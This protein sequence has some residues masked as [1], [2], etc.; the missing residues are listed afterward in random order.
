[1]L[2]YLVYFPHEDFVTCASA[3]FC[4][5]AANAISTGSSRLPS[6]WDHPEAPPHPLAVP[7]AAPAGT[8]TYVNTPVLERDSSPIPADREINPDGHNRPVGRLDDPAGRSARDEKVGVRPG[9]SY[10]INHR[11]NKM[12]C[13]RHHKSPPRGRLPQRD[14]HSRYTPVVLQLSP[15]TTHHLVRARDPGGIPPQFVSEG[16]DAPPSLCTNARSKVS[17]KGYSHWTR[18]NPQSGISIDLPVARRP[19][20]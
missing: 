1:M 18:T 16:I 14:K 11:L 5:S 20:C 13:V 7:H 6:K 9:K 12:R 15:H 17:R 3:D 19:S 8:T 10:P 2:N 4:K